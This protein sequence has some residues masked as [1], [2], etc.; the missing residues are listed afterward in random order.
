M[1]YWSAITGI[2]W[3]SGGVIMSTNKHIDKICCAAIIAAVLLTLVFMNGRELGHLE[4]S[5][6]KGY[7]SRL[8]DT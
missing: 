4:V 8:F 2:I 5:A 7:E 6:V 3:D 1:L